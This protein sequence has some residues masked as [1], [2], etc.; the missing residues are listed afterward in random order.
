MRYRLILLPI[1]HPAEWAHFLWRVCI[2][3]SVLACPTISDSNTVSKRGKVSRSIV[4]DGAMAVIFSTAYASQRFPTLFAAFFFHFS[5][6]YLL[7]IYYCFYTDS[8]LFQFSAS[9]R[10][11]LTREPLV[12]NHSNTRLSYF[13]PVMVAVAEKPFSFQ[14]CH[15]FVV[16][17]HPSPARLSKYSR[18]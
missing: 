8:F 7:S 18:L 15:F 12:F 11:I 5:K 1:I 4:A 3:R 2:I 9:T 14:K 6:I 10:G 17:Y 13:Y 16:G